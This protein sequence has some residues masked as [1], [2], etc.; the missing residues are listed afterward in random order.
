MS[1]LRAPCGTYYYSHVPILWHT[2]LEPLVNPV[3]HNT[4]A[5]CR[6]SGTQYYSHV[7]LL[8]NTILYNQACAHPVAHITTAMCRSCSSLDHSDHYVS[9]I[10]RA[11]CRSCGTHYYCHVAFLWHTF[12]QP[13]ADPMAHWIIHI[14]TR[15]TLLQPC[16]DP[17]AHWIIHIITR[18]TLLQPCGDPMA[19]WI[20]HI[21]ERHTIPQPYKRVHLICITHPHVSCA[22]VSEALANC[23]HVTVLSVLVHAAHLSPHACFPRGNL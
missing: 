19:H 3:A 14:F 1:K 9:Y 17:M 23:R 15:H 12:L 7:P 5:M 8:W 16:A 13:C 2:L 4:T 22:D 18:H 10:T 21:S 20:I 6:S 11:M